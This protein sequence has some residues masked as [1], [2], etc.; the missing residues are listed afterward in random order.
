[1]ASSSSTRRILY[2]VGGLF[3][4]VVLIG[5]VGRWMGWFGGGAEGL[6]VEVAP[7]E[8]RDITQVVTA[9]GRAQPEVEVTISPDVS[10]EIVELPVE[11][12]QMVQKGDLLARLNQENPRAVVEQQRANV[13]Q[14]KAT[15]AER[16]ADSLSARLDFERQKGLYEKG[17]ISESEF[18]NSRSQYQQ[19]VARLQAARFQVQSAQASLQDAIERLEKT[20]IYAPMSGTVSTLNVE[21]GERVVGTERV[22]GTEMMTIAQLDQMEMEVDVNEN[23][24]VNVSMTDSASVEIDAYPDETFRGS[25]TEIANSA[26]VSNQGTQDQVTNFPVKVRIHGVQ[27][28]EPTLANGGTGEGV[29]RPEVPSAP[30]VMPKLRPGMSGTVEIYTQTTPN[31]VAV[32]IQAVTVRDFNKVRGG[33]DGKAAS[34]QSKEDLRKVVFVAEADSAR[35]VEVTTGIADETHIEIRSGLSG[36]EQVIMGP[37]SAVSRALSPGDKIRIQSEN[38]QDGSVLAS[39]L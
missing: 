3:L 7:A 10:G 16:R 4:A 13:S 33:S 27:N 37:Y 8:R 9:F 11:E 30:R 39:G 29:T 35:M 25:V 1:M 15:L 21:Q 34:G 38:D 6:E 28:I 24:V 12:G 2:A 17:V 22:Q 18:E 36:G 23:D 14:A 32:P 20:R 31:T 5:G 19:A 26:R